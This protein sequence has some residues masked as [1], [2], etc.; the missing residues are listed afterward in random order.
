MNAAVPLRGQERIARWCGG[1]RADLIAAV[2][3]LL[4]P[5]AFAPFDGYPLAVVSPALLFLLW[6]HAT[7]RF[8]FR[9]GFSYGAGMFGFGVCWV[10][11]SMYDNGGVSLSQSLFLTSFFVLF[12][13]LFPAALGYGV[14]R[15]AHRVDCS[16]D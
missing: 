9:C 4:L 14:A 13:A 2:A 3:G 5:L 1:A 16:R 12:L 11:V 6:L 8:A 10:I 7:P 15:V